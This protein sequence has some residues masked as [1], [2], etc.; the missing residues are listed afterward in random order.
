MQRTPILYRTGTLFIQ[1][2]PV[3]N[4]DTVHTED[5]IPVQN[6]GTGIVEHSDVCDRQRENKFQLQR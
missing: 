5:S 2:T 1:R 3:Q 4:W 6:W